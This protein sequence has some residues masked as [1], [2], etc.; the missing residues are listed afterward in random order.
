MSLPIHA[1]VL[2]R[3]SQVYRVQ[4]AHRLACLFTVPTNANYKFYSPARFYV[5][6]VMKMILSRLMC[7]L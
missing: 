3:S 7:R 2:L 5:S 1:T 4:L 6:F